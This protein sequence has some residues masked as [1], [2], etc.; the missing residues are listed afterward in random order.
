M[1]NEDFNDHSMDSLPEGDSLQWAREAY[2]R[3]KK[4][5]ELS[6]KN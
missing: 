6:K 5:Q 3:L 1:I 2:A 4:E